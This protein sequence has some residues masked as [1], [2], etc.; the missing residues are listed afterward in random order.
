MQ[1]NY[2]D[3]NKSLSELK[4]DRNKLAIKFHP[5]K[6]K[7]EDVAGKIAEINNEYDYVTNPKNRLKHSQ[8]KKASPGI[9]PICYDQAQKIFHALT[10]L[11]SVDYDL[12]I[13]TVTQVTNW[14]DVSEAY[15][16]SYGIHTLLH[17]QRA[18]PKQWN[19]RIIKIVVMAN[20]VK[21]KTAEEVI[22]DLYNH[23]SQFF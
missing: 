5:D 17:I 1:L 19:D 13:R 6:Y 3:I 11:K 21:T 8:Q 22:K 9:D 15:Y 16:R 14:K 20:Q 2:F 7:G 4:K 23:I 12:L 18:V 10:N